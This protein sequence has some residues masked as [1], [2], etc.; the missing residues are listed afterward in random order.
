[1][2]LREVSKSDS[3]INHVD[4]KK[5]SLPFKKFNLH[6]YVKTPTISKES[7]LKFRLKAIFF[8][9][10]PFIHIEI[11][12][13]GKHCSPFCLKKGGSDV[14]ASIM[15]RYNRFSFGKRYEVDKIIH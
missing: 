8:L 1:L 5:K 10:P 11:V 7:H 9:L 3:L 14:K 12:A 13:L 2:K 4:F 6:L 15:N